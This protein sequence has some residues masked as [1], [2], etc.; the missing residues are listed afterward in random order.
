M[1]PIFEPSSSP[2]DN[3]RQDNYNP[4]SPDN[5]PS[6]F[7]QQHR[8]GRRQHE[9]AVSNGGGDGGA[10]GEGAGVGAGAGLLVDGIS[11]ASTSPL[12]AAAIDMQNNGF[13]H[14]DGGGGGGGA[15]RA[16]AAEVG[17]RQFPLSGSVISGSADGNL[18]ARHV[19]G[20]MSMQGNSGD[21]SC[22]RDGGG[23]R[24]RREGDSDA[25][26]AGVG[27][28]QRAF[29]PHFHGAGQVSGA[30]GGGRGLKGG[31]TGS[32]GGGG[33][34]HDD[35]FDCQTCRSGNDD[36]DSA[37]VPAEMAAAVD[38]TRSGHDLRDRGTLAEPGCR[39]T[40]GGGGGVG[41]GGSRQ[42]NAPR[43][44][45][46]SPDE[47]MLDAAGP[48]LLDT[49]DLRVAQGKLSGGAGEG[50]SLRATRAEEEERGGLDYVAANGIV[51]GDGGG[52]EEEGGDG[53]VND[54]TEHNRDRHDAMPSEQHHSCSPRNHSPQQPQHH[55]HLDDSHILE[56][57]GASTAAYGVDNSGGGGGNNGPQPSDA[58]GPRRHAV[59]PPSADRHGARPLFHRQYL[60]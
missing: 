53:R 34:G 59:V 44:F 17:P 20:A 46:G 8:H 7:H 31:R 57:L 41:E 40:G 47:E 10:E 50:H 2:E 4:N 37:A 16:E 45:F 5:R 29:G 54:R 11:P 14:A 30:V 56:Q 1:A 36:N 3:L 38:G 48:G 24:E 52:D 19:A 26:S 49:I 25:F 43:H 23:A 55:D 18:A 21:T 33:G 22:S 58:L 32:E 27:A 60:Q 12:H 15:T 28:Q 13:P 51:S 42:H 6:H 39:G 35:R 9:S